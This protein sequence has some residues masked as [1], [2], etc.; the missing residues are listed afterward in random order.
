[1]KSK[2]LIFK[3]FFLLM[4]LLFLFLSSCKKENGEDDTDPPGQRPVNV[5]EVIVISENHTIL[6]SAIYAAGLTAMLQGPGPFT[7]F[8][9]TDGAFTA[10]HE[11]TLEALF[12]D[13][14]GALKDFLLYHVL[15]IELMSVSFS[16]GMKAQTASGQELTVTV[17]EEGF[18]INEV[19][20]IFSDIETENGVVHMVDGLL[21]RPDS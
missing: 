11:D 10:L 2:I 9:P 3:G 21:F 6:S 17:T 8:A 15:D 12:E 7:V 5:I 18:L 19:K 1:M 20:V 13:P 14:S 16:N 4:G